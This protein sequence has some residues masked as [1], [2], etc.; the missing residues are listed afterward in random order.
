MSKTN[1]LAVSLSTF[2]F[3]KD[4]QELITGFA[5][6][7]ILV[8][9]SII[10]LIVLLLI[11]LFISKSK[12]N[13]LEKTERNKNEKIYQHENSNS[14]NVSPKNSVSLFPK[15][16]F[17]IILFFM[18]MTLGSLY[19][20]KNMGVYYIVLKNDLTMEQSQDLKEKTNSSTDFMKHG[21]SSRFIPNGSGKYE[22]IL[23]NGY[24]N[25][26]KADSDLEKVKSMNLGFQPYRVGPQYVANYINKIRYLQN[27]IFN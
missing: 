23:F 16:I 12:G 5:L 17:S 2:A 7:L 10:V 14:I 20:V 24:I 27:G 22:L 19:Y 25:D 6:H 3:L 15:I 4:I 8:G 1:I 21:L 18:L 13:D 11:N 9:I 26:F